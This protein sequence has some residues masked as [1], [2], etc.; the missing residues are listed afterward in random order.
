MTESIQKDSP[1]ASSGRKAVVLVG[2]GAVARDCPRE[3]V[4]R[5]KALE[6]QRRGGV[7]LATP[8]ERELDARIRDWPRTAENDPYRQGLAALA[9]R[10]RPHL[11]GA[12]LVLAFNEFC[13]PSLTSAI[14]DLI[15]AGLTDISV[16]PSML[17]PGGV[18]SET[19]IP[20]SI[21]P[22]RTRYPH[23]V[24][25]YAWPFDLD[26]IAGMLGRHL[27]PFLA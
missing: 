2:H 26:L 6:A 5:L 16:V 7:S 22:L 23:V 25:R 3:W 9:E 8:E 10:L 15:A 4:M 12:R 27:D 18:H 11:R 13:A 14:E 24:L 20:E 19:D 1:T 17:T 21:A